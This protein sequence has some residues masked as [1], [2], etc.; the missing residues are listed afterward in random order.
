MNLF[1]A[2]NMFEKMHP[3]KKIDYQ[4]DEKCHRVHE[5][6]YTDGKPNPIHHVE[7]DKVKITV[8]GMEPIYISIAPHRECYTWEMIKGLINS[9]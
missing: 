8:E 4:F 7:S 5:L 6:Y 2:Q 1:E 9:K 3:G